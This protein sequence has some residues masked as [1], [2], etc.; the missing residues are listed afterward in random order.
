MTRSG[1]IILALVILLATGCGGNAGTDIK[2][3]P[4]SGTGTTTTGT[5]GIQRGNVSVTF[6]LAGSAR[7]L[8]VRDL[9]QNVATVIV[10]LINPTTGQDVVPPI[11]AQTTNEAPALTVTFTSVP[12]G[13]YQVV[14]ELLDSSGNILGFATPTTTIYPGMTA[15]VTVSSSVTLNSI[16]VAPSSA[17]IV[18]G[19]TVDFTAMGPQ[20]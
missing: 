10:H 19:A 15:M 4:L 16:A 8:S 11:T 20:R 18:P 1:T 2:P 7:A 13:N 5:A 12:S 9:P 6:H 3:Q 17:S 14:A